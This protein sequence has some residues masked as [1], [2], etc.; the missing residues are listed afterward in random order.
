M[1]TQKTANDYREERKARLAKA[2]KQ[3]HKKSRKLGGHR[4]NKKTK[5]GIAVALAAVVVLGVVALILNNEG[6][7]ERMK[8]F[9]T[10]G[11]TKYSSVE[12]EYHYK[13][14]H[15]YIYNMS[16]QYDSYYGAGAG[17]QYTGY[18]CSKAPAEQVYPY[19]DYKLADGSKPTWKQYLEHIALEKMQR[20]Y[21]LVDMANAEG[22]QLTAEALNEIET[23]IATLRTNI[24]TEATQ[25]G[26][27]V[28][29]LSNYLQQS[30]G[31]GVN[32]KM[33]R[34][35]VERETLA[36]EYN[37][38]LLE[39]N[40]NGY[41]KEQLEAEYAKDPSAYNCVDFRLFTITAETPQLD[42]TASNEE[43]KAA[44]EKAAA[45]AKK[46]AE[47]MLE[48]ITDEES[49]IKLAEEYATEKQKESYDYSDP[50][51]TLSTYVQ[52]SLIQ[53]NFS[54]DIIKWLYSTDTKANEK[55]M[56]EVSGT[57]YILYMI[58][59]TY[60]D[61]STI[62]VDVRHILYQ[63]DENAEDQDAALAA[64]KAKADAALKKINESPTKLDTFLE[65]C[66]AESTDT[67]S[68]TNGGLYEYVGRGQ[69]VAEFEAWALDPNRKEGDVAVVETDYGYHVMY[70]EK[71]HTKPMWQITIGQKLAS[72]ALT[73]KLNEAFKSP[74]YAIPANSVEYQ[75]LTQKVYDDIVKLHYTSAAT[76]A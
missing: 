20:I 19:D 70:F 4:M 51:T 40:A 41:T 17:Y 46:K 52:K 12:Y 30:F 32:E 3:N 9:E 34:E 10:A 23:S 67:G 31:K 53:S 8:T 48:K 56:F 25:S 55:K 26:S 50:K 2:S 29:S 38:Y 45:D 54:E 18:D 36:T 39:K 74:Q 43:K 33:F 62:P 11:G 75:K 16:A 21:A 69:Y 44:N 57:Y 61:D 60:R 24:E 37:E 47:E 22:F 64:A 28:P 13:S 66:A 65:I 1:A 76:A 35:I 73:A 72:D 14:T 58:K 27:L 6:V 59:P 7:F 5:I 49:F 68:N 63:A 42:S 71:A 15:Q